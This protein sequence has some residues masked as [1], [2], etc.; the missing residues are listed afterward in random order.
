MHIFILVLQYSFGLRYMSILLL[1]LKTPFAFNPP[2]M[3]SGSLG[4][5]S[6]S[7]SPIAGGSAD[8]SVTRTSPS[9]L[10]A[11]TRAGTISYKFLAFALAFMDLARDTYQKPRIAYQTHKVV[12]LSYP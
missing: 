12:V 3:P 4:K 8:L 7:G 6:L 5:G 10:M 11:S 9:A 1:N 2:S